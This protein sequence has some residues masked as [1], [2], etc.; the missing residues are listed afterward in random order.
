MTA[1]AMLSLL[2]ANNLAA[3][4]LCVFVAGFSGT[5]FWKLIRVLGRIQAPGR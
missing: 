1:F 2:V 5:L 3:V 4:V